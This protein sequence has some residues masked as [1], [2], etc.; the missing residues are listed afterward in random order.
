ME[1]HEAFT[2]DALA[3]LLD[4]LAMESSNHLSI[5]SHY[6]TALTRESATKSRPLLIASSDTIRERA[7]SVLAVRWHC[8]DRHLTL[9]EQ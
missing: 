1:V 4:S 6:A 2:L 9:W 8:P 5:T 7:G 3:H